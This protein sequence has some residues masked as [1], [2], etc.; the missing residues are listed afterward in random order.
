MVLALGLV[1]SSVTLDGVLGEPLA[2]TNEAGG[3]PV[4]LLR[5]FTRG[6][7]GCEIRI[8]LFGIQPNPWMMI[9]SIPLVALAECEERA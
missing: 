6:V 8:R 5:G 4:I 1:T 7:E 2:K 9:S 3:N